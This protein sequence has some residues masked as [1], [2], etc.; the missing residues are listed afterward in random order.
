M[1]GNFSDWRFFQDCLL[2]A[3]FYF[4]GIRF[5]PAIFWRT[6]STEFV[7]G[8]SFWWF[9]FLTDCYFGGIRF[10][11]EIVFMEYFDGIRYERIRF[12]RE[13]LLWW[14]WRDF[15]RRVNFWQFS[16]LSMSNTSICTICY[17]MHE[18]CLDDKSWRIVD[19]ENKLN[20]HSF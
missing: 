18:R 15:C 14:F 8:E 19:L 3:G 4:N 16:E 5:W 11:R 10:W 6:F 1:T 20:T 2:L 17:G 12:W 9:S 13:I 7:F